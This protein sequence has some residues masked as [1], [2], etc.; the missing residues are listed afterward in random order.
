MRLTA[1][2]SLLLKFE[3]LCIPAP[4]RGTPSL[5]VDVEIKHRKPPRP[6]SVTEECRIRGVPSELGKKRSRVEEG[7]MEG[8]VPGKLVRPGAKR[9]R[10]DA[11]E[12]GEAE[13]ER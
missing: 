1:N 6:S 13:E 9:G 10:G 4:M 7:E 5:S 12:V 2:L 3:D 11:V 8:E